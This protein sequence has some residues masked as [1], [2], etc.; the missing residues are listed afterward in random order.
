MLNRKGII[1]AGGN[2]SRLFPLT[3]SISKHLLP[4]YNKPMIYYPLSVLM[5]ADI[6]E[7]LIISQKTFIPFYKKLFGDGSNLGI[8]ISYK[9][10]KNPSGIPE[11]FILG[12]S[13][14]K[15]DPVALILG[16][17]IFYGSQLSG[18]LKD[19]KNENSN[20][21]FSSKVN[22]PS[23]FGIIKYDKNKLPK[24]IIEKPKR[25]IGNRAATGLYFYNNDV[26][27]IAKNLKPSSRGELEI[28]DIN[29]YYLA[30]NSLKIIDLYRG[31][32]WLD[33]GS[34]ENLFQC[35]SLIHSIEKNTDVMIGCLEEIAH[36]KKWISKKKIKEIISLNSDNE[37][38][39]Y[40]KKLIL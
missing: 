16:D 38:Y 29:N 33:T 10:Q 39:Q 23:E 32:L 25:F 11:A 37:Y 22:N 1:L 14:I 21:I 30:R 17:N 34:F 8:S 24:K 5:L 20:I 18:Q 7:I 3:Q 2:G 19:A 26:I 31:T 28:S 13:F 12:E 4:V 6:K 36:L 9:I 40:L 35:S 15:K 27:E